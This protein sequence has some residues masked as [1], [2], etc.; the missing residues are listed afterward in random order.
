[1][2]DQN[3]DRGVRQAA[4]YEG[5]EVAARRAALPS[6]EA[7]KKLVHKANADKTTTKIWE[8]KDDTDISRGPREIFRGRC[9]QGRTGGS[10]RSQVTG[11]TPTTERTSVG[12]VETDQAWQA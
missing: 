6:P 10:M 12:G 9:P 3:T 5:P 11:C 8:P 7:M 1:M 2:K 4:R